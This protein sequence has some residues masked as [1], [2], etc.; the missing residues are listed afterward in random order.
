[1]SSSGVRESD[2][3]D[4]R[5]KKLALDREEDLINSFKTWDEATS[6]SSLAGG[7]TQSSG[8]GSAPGN[9]MPLQGD[10]WLGQYGNQ[11]EITTIQNGQLNV[12]RQSGSS[13]PIL[14]VNPES[15]S[16]DFLDTMVPG[17]DIL[18]YQEQLI[19]TVS[20]TITIRPKLSISIT[21]IVGIGGNIVE[22]TVADTS[23]LT[24][25]DK[26][27][28][29]G[30]TNFN[31]VDAIITITSGTTF[32]Y[33]LGTTASTTPETSGDVDRGN[34]QTQDGE[35]LTC[36][37]NTIVHFIF[38]T[39]TRLFQIDAATIA[40]GSGGGPEFVDDVFRVIGDG[41]PTKKLA[42]EVDGFTAATTRVMTP[43]NEDTVLAGLSVAQT[44]TGVNTFENHT[45]FGSTGPFADSGFLRFANDTIFAAGRTGADDGNIELK[46]TTQDE[47]DLTNSNNST[48]KLLLRAQ[49]AIDPDNLFLISQ[50]P[51]SA[52]NA[53]LTAPNNLA[54][55]TNLVTTNVLFSP[56]EALFGTDINLNSFDVKNVDRAIFIED[57]GIVASNT[58]STILLNSS[59]Q[60]QFNTDE[61]NDFMFSMSNNA[62]FVFDHDLLDNDNRIFS[63]LSDSTNINSAAFVDIVKSFSIP[64]DNQIIGSLSFKGG[65]SLGSG[66]VEYAA[67]TAQMFDVTATS[68]DGILRFETTVNSSI[69]NFMELNNGGNGMIDMFRS[70][71]MNNNK[72]AD[73]NPTT[74]TDFTTVTAASGDFVWIIDATD[75]LSKKVNASDFLGGGASQTPIL[76]DVDYDGFDIFDLSNIE[77]RDTTGA[78]STSA[79]AIWVDSG[80]MNLQ[81]GNLSDTI[82][83]R[84]GANIELRL[85][86]DG[87]LT[88]IQDGHKIIPQ[89]TAFQIISSSTTDR[90]ELTNGT[91]STNA[92][93]TIENTRTTW[94][95]QTNST[96][97]YALQL[98]Q[99]NNSPA[100]FRT[101]VNIDMIAENSSSVDTIYARISASSQDF[102]AATE[103][104]LLQLGIVSG[105]TLISGI[106]IEGSS[107]GGA[108]DA[109]IGFFGE[110]PVAQQQLDATPTTTE[111]STALRNLGL[112]KL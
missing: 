17:S 112:T 32:T 98:I 27:D 3:T 51:G 76:Q 101:I 49:H 10:N 15:G 73:I 100:D 31:L 96:E 79:N 21:N 89:S 77:F 90:I 61:I 16:P 70:L 72:I 12:S 104:G 105:G 91:G 107:S 84:L 34:I 75:G 4:K 106:D 18:F 81:A 55:L 69:V 24:D 94:R 108:N 35:N 46:F 82:D 2:S 48:V 83:F 11:F 37:V 86:E 66:V 6:L 71:V 53:F 67:I 7:G 13:S 68:L 8:V 65:T 102:T 50:N 40:T 78:P 26:V 56:T 22:V 39:V 29:S 28:I 23:L 30:T 41:D 64:L 60:F 88:W 87:E 109:L 42:F 20:Q 103:D 38:N 44:F 36:P 63:V 14:V 1:M 59:N 57:S 74:I 111:I 9:F 95:T 47:L 85:E 19:H 62:A 97:A 45:I 33:D 110:T 80:G 58:D 25:G 54:I 43:P 92:I 99:N 5:T 52:G 93:V